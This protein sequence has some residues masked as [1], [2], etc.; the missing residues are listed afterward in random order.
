MTPSRMSR[1]DRWHVQ[2]A[3]FG[4][5]VFKI[6]S[7]RTSEMVFGRNHRQRHGKNGQL[8]CRA[9]G[10]ANQFHGA[11]KGHVGDVDRLPLDCATAKMRSPGCSRP[12]RAAALPQQ[13]A[14]LAGASSLSREAPMPKSESFM[15]IERVSIS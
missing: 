12:L 6:H 10:A 15:A 5:L 11:R 4:L 13:F 2:Y 9:L 3:G 8:H 14:N 1:L 7:S